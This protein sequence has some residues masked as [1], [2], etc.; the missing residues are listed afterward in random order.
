M[1]IELQGF[2]FTAI[3]GEALSAK[4]YMFMKLSADMTVVGTTALTDVPCGVLQ[5]NPPIGGAAEVMVY[6]ITKILAGVGALA[7]GNLVG[8]DAAGT[9]VV[10]DPDGVADNYYVGQIVIGCGAGEIG[11]ALV[12]CASPVIQS[13][14]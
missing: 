6:G 13:G 4:Q 12:N 14:S 8:C 9:A 2:K 10:V 5:N 1:A 11:S 7:A 3:A